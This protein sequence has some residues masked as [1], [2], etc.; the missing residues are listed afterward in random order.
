MRVLRISLF[1]LL[2]GA[3]MLSLAAVPAQAGWFDRG[4]KGSGDVVTESREVEEFTFIDCNI[5]ADID[6]TIGNEYSLT[7]SVDDNLMD[8]I[9]TE[10]RGKTLEI[11]ADESFSTRRGCRIELTVKRLEGFDLSGSGDI[12]VT[13]LK[14]EEFEFDLS[15]DRVTTQLSLQ[16]LQLQ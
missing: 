10:V 15:G 13:G 11:S 16:L 5:G 8:I 14:E 7:I 9:R 1:A 2:T 4:I 12:R 6:V 3:I